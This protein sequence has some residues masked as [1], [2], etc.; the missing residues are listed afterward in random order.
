LLSPDPVVVSIRA[1]LP[2]KAEA[3]AS[4]RQVSP[5]ADMPPKKNA[6]EVTRNPSGG[7][8]PQN[9]KTVAVNTVGI[10]V[11]AD[12]DGVGAAEGWLGANVA[13]GKGAG[14]S[15]GSMLGIDDGRGVG[16][17]DGRSDAEYATRRL[18]T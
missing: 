8:P 1:T 7:P 16:V 11:G 9:S 14:A 18:L 13:E 5:P 3:D 2:L 12:G 17:R 6:P 15:E 10:K 4:A